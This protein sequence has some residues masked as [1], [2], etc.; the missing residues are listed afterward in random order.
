MR[1]EAKVGDKIFL[2]THTSTSEELAV[3][4]IFAGGDD[5]LGGVIL[6]IRSDKAGMADVAW[7]CKLVLASMRKVIQRKL[8]MGVCAS[9]WC[10]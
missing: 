7:I 8:N 3:A 9:C 1:F 10:V 4:E 5:D 2:A 6:E